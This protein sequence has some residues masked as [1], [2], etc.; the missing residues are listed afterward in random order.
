MRDGE[1]G[2]GTGRF[3]RCLAWHDAALLAQSNDSG[4]AIATGAL[5]HGVAADEQ[6]AAGGEIGLNINQLAADAARLLH[7]AK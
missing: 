6:A 1:S 7:R 5:L 2:I 4:F 3:G